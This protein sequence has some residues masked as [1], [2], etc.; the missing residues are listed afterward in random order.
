MEFFHRPLP[1]LRS[2]YWMIQKLGCGGFGKVY[3]IRHRASREY[4]AAKHQ[5]WVTP[6]TQ[7]TARREAAVL[8]RLGA[9]HQNHI[10][11]YIDYFEGE[12][13]SV[14]LTEYLEGGELFQRISSKDYELTEAKC[15]DFFR[16]I[17]R[18]IEFIH[19]KSILHL[20]LK[21]QNVVLVSPPPLPDKENSNRSGGSAAG[22]HMALD[23]KISTS[24]TASMGHGGSGSVD[25][26][27]IIDFGLAREL[28]LYA[29]RIPITMCGTLEFM[30]PEVMRCSHASP[31]SDMWSAG[32]ILYMMLSGGVSPFWAGSEYRTQ[33][34]IIRGIFSLDHPNFKDIS[35]SALNCIS[36]VLEI[37]GARRLSATAC[38]EHQWLTGSYLDTL[39]QLETTWMRKYLAKRRWQRW[40]NTVKA[41]NRMQRLVAS[42]GNGNRS[43]G[44]GGAFDDHDHDFQLSPFEKGGSFKRSP[45]Q[46]RKSVQVRPTA[47][48]DGD[49]EEVVDA[50]AIDHA[51]DAVDRTSSRERASSTNTWV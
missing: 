10:V 7:R 37:D 18:G 46:A 1:E 14:L 12:E 11:H 26:L 51:H 33:R 38:L 8:R 43:E 29:D 45:R 30:S 22:G 4:C 6:D 5:K 34:R 47:A 23:R 20:D 9:G 15:R 49:V 50:S 36:S 16:Q 17:L 48:G 35:N 13:Q 3:L 40:F 31:A 2:E 39:K 32:V 44:G 28:G 21:P 27:K 19:S 42:H 24:S 25:K 41:M